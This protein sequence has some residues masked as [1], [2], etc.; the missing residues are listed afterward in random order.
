M[1]YLKHCFEGLYNQ[2]TC[3]EKLGEIEDDLR[4]MFNEYNEL[5]FGIKQSATEDIVTQPS[6]LRIGRNARHSSYMQLRLS[7]DS[8]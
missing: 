1:G 4:K 3:N 8:I 6:T 5:H 7:Q 2:D